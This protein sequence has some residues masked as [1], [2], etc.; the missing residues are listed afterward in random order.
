MPVNNQYTVISFIE[1][2]HASKHF[3]L[4]KRKILQKWFEKNM[5]N[6]YPS[7]QQKKEL[8]DEAGLSVEQVNTW[9]TNTRRKYKKKEIKLQQESQDIQANTFG[10]ERILG[11]NPQL[12]E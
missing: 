1:K 5:K 2:A 4:A 8:A 11:E 12:N 10:L 6:P 7:L 9:F 3:P